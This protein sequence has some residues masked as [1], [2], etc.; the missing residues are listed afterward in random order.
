MEA[1][2]LQGIFSNSYFRIPDYQRGYAWEQRQLGELWDDIS[3]IR[4]EDGEYKKHYTGTIFVEK[5]VPSEDER[6]LTGAVFYNVVDGQQRL[7]TISILLFELLSKS[8]IGYGGQRRSTLIERYLYTENTTGA[9]RSYKFSYEQTDK[10]YHFL[11]NK[12]FGDKSVLLNSKEIN[13]YSNNL[14]AAK[15]FFSEKIDMMA[16]Y[17]RDELFIKITS[18]L[19]FDIRSIEKDL[20]VQAVFETIN[21]RGK[22]LSVLEKLKNRLIYLT[23]KLQCPK[24]DKSKLRKKISLST[25]ITLSTTC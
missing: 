7:T 12:I 4:H 22:P 3:D 24:E 9:S 23:D 11:L 18:A 14:L 20:D 2:N 25:F 8:D 16:D 1:I 21:N 19:Y 15:T 5:T 13:K 10:N 17:E 6:W